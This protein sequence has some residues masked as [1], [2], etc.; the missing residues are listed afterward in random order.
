MDS[1]L[2]LVGTY[3]YFGWTAFIVT[4]FLTPLAMRV[5]HRFGVLDIPDR[6][7]KPHA[8]PIP[9]LGGAVICIAWATS[10]TAAA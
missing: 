7:L 8:Q 2:N 9:Y 3:Q 4:V 1:F 10:V 6:K 5:A